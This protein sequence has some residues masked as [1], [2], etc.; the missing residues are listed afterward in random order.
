MRKHLNSR[1]DLLNTPIV[2]VD[3][4]HWTHMVNIPKERGLMFYARSL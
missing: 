1:Y 4:V 2:R 3:T